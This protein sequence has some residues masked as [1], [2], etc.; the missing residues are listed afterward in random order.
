MNEALRN[1]VHLEVLRVLD[2]RMRRVPGIVTG[3]DPD[4]FTVKVALQ[5]SGTL[6]GWIQIEQL[7]TGNGF[8]VQVAPNIGDPG[9]VEFHENDRRAGVFVGAASNEKFPPVPIQAGEM[10]FK[11]K[12]GQSIYLK[13]DGSVTA[14]D[15]AGG[16]LVLKSGVATLVDAGGASVQLDGTG[17]L[18]ITLAPGKSMQINGGATGC[19]VN[20]D[21]SGNIIL[22]P[23][24]GGRVYLGG[25]SGAKAIARDGDPVSGG[26]IHATSEIGAST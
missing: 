7:Q 14:V 4:S 11:A 20:M 18:L 26:I 23:A 15:G 6:T 25:E 5:P 13:D 21:G 17:N 9:W 24:A 22:T 16:S 1:L 19:G 2:R 3:Y 10:L 12:W 8:G